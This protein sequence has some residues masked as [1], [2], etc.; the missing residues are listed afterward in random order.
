[1][2]KIR[3][4]LMA[5]CL[6]VSA[7][8]VAPPA[9]AADS[10]PLPDDQVFNASDEVNVWERSLLPLR[11]DPSS[12]TE[13]IGVANNPTFFVNLSDRSGD[14]TT[15]K[16]LAVYE[17]G[18]SI[19]FSFTESAATDTTELSDN[20]PNVEFVAARVTGSD[21]GIPDTFSDA[22]DLISGDNVNQNAS[23]E[24]VDNTTQI[25]SGTTDFSYTPSQPGHYVLFVLSD[26]SG[27][28]AVDVDSSTGNITLT[29]NVTVLGTDAISVQRTPTNEISQETSDPEP[30]DDITFDVDATNQLGAS[31]V[32]H[33]LA[34]YN[35]DELKSSS[36]TLNVDSSEIDDDFD[37]QNNS[38]FDHS[39]ASVEGVADVESGA[40]VNGI[41]L[42][43]G[44]VSRSVGFGTVID[45]IA[46]DLGGTAP[47]TNRNGDT[48]LNASLDADVDE[49]GDHTLTIETNDTWEE[50]TYQ[51]V[52]VGTLENN[53]S[54]ITSD[55]GTLEIDT[56]GSGGGSPDVGDDDD[57]DDDDRRPGG[58]GGGG[59]GGTGDV[60][61]V[62]SSVAE[63]L[64]ENDIST[65]NVRSTETVAPTVDSEAGTA[66]ATTETSQ[67]VESIE[68]Q[69][70][71]ESTEVTVTDLDPDTPTETPA[72]GQSVS[73]QDISVTESDGDASDTEATVRFR[74]SNERIQ[75]RGTTAENLRAFRLVDGS[76]QGLETSVAEE[77]DNGVVLEAQTPGFSLFAV[78]TVE[79]PE[80]SLS[81]DPTTA[82]AG[83][84]V[85]LSASGSTDPDGEIVS[86]DWSVDGQSFTGESVTVSLDETGEY[87]VELV[88]TDDS[89]ETDT[90]TQT[91]TIAQT[92]TATPE[93]ETATPGPETTT[94]GPD[95]ATET[96]TTTSDP[97]I[98]GF[99]FTTAILALLA[100]ALI[101]LGRRRT[102]E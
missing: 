36:H 69:T 96:P 84:D 89:G 21:E 73:L 77:T 3:A 63:V 79:P 44:R 60:N 37:I 97:L 99:G 45:F 12:A 68:L 65:T 101:A 102:D 46:E 25:T 76:W 16:Q 53:K 55:I 85:Q 4:V 83:E 8:A 91:L 18:T 27:G 98:P 28:N 20:D 39:I 75:E 17:P 94:P 43:D 9:S 47:T 82:Q 26:D 13:T 33:M 59:G 7:T 50:G 2:S 42:S 90:I 6:V 93:P 56:S 34:V 74:I 64:E 1:M 48:I 19:S 38:T 88:V 86:Y 10:D 87:T 14:T 15:N 78:S 54:A 100:T 23:F 80:A 24:L 11:A 51:Y 32:T 57:D 49:S 67:N 52:Y 61:N 92:D 31:G 5:V 30:G 62:P 95:T 70:T 66:T 72:P 58:G 41:D 29:E 35:Q 71:D 40:S 22:V 81:L